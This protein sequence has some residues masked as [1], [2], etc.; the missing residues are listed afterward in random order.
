MKLDLVLVVW[1]DAHS[2]SAG[3]TGFKDIED[4]GEYLVSSVGWVLKP[5]HGGKAKHLT[6]CQSYTPDEDVDHV[7]HIPNG[8][9]RSV[10]HL[11]IGNTYSLGYP[12]GIQ[13]N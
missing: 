2:D 5:E 7:L 8:M 13:E 11:S 10:K 9:V 12:H 1:A 4:E 6:I 3:W